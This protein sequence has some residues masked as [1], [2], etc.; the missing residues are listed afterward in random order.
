MYFMLRVISDRILYLVKLKYVLFNQ[1]K[2]LHFIPFRASFIIDSE[3]LILLHS[4][5]K[6]L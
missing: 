6:I 2:S 4:T 1:R 5:I 3:N